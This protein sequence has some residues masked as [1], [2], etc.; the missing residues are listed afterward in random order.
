MRQM[1]SRSPAS[2]HPLY[3]QL[4][5]P[6]HMPYYSPQMFHQ[7]PYQAKSVT[8]TGGLIGLLRGDADPSETDFLESDQEEQEFVIVILTS[9]CKASLKA[10]KVL[11]KELL[12]EG[13]HSTEMK[14]LEID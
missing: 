2:H 13:M 5:N 1:L 12:Q 10:Y 11:A 3:Q 4:P 9:L 14:G 6:F 8:P 7:M